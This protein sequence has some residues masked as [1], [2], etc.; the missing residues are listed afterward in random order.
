M[1][2]GTRKANTSAG[3][4]GACYGEPAVHRTLIHR[5]ID[6]LRW[7]VTSID[8]GHPLGL[9]M[10]VPN[11]GVPPDECNLKI[12]N[13]AAGYPNLPSKAGDP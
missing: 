3:E 1:A 10:P 6:D 12:R 5:V 9:E 4:K 13:T 11:L 2:N 8:P 7:G